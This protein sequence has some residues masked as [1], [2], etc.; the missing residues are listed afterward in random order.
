MT[1]ADYDPGDFFDEMFAGAGRPRPAARALTQVV[2]ALP[3]GEIERR[4]RSAERALMAMGITFNV[5]GDHEGTERIF[6][7]DVIPRIVSAAEWRTIERGSQPAHPRG[8]HVR[9]GGDD[10][11]HTA[12]T[13][14][15]AAPG[16]LPG[17]RTARHRVPPRAGTGGALRQRLSRD[18]AAAGISTPGRRRR[19]ARMAG[20]LLPGARVDR[21]RSDEQS[22]PLDHPRHAWVGT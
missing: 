5:Y 9:S 8:L 3:A 1:F 15:L 7:F 22:L 2:D 20:R 11:R 13:R 14:P 19:L 16:R 4:P 10:R 18:G 6:P 12:P 17:F 21:R